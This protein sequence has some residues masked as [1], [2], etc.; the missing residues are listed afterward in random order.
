MNDNFDFNSD[1]NNDSTLGYDKETITKG[2]YTALGQSA[3]VL[4]TGAAGYAVYKIA[5]KTKD[6]LFK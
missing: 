4:V 2:F 3:A 5:G 6:K 1:T